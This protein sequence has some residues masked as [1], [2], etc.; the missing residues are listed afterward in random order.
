MKKTAGKSPGLAR[1]ELSHKRIITHANHSHSELTAFREHP[2]KKSKGGLLKALIFVAVLVVIGGVVGILS[3]R[4]QRLERRRETVLIA[5][6]LEAAERAAERAAE[7]MQ[8][9]QG[10]QLEADQAM[11]GIHADV[12]SALG[13][14][15][16][17]APA[18]QLSKVTRTDR[19][20]TPASETPATKAVPRAAREETPDGILS[21][22]ELER[23]LRKKTTGSKAAPSTDD[24]TAA[25]PRPARTR[26]GEATPPIRLNGW[27]AAQLHTQ[28]TATISEAHTS[29]REAEAS[30]G[31]ARAAAV[32]TVVKDSRA[33]IE[34]GALSLETAVEDARGAM[35]DLRK[36]HTLV[37]AERVAVEQARSEQAEREAALRREV[38]A[39]RLAEKELG[40]ARRGVAMARE[41]LNQHQFERAVERLEKTRA[42]LS[43]DSA[44]AH[45]DGPLARLQR[46][47]AL[48]S[49]LIDQASQR[50]LSW[51]WVQD[52]SPV[53]VIGADAETVHLKARRVPWSEVTLPQFLKMVD[54]LLNDSNIRLS[55]R[56]N[57][58]LSA[59][60][61]CYERGEKDKATDF[62]RRATSLI[63]A[64]AD[65]ARQLLAEPANP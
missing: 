59:A 30:L 40:E 10:W 47:Q 19:P 20:G 4:Q 25:A 39:R 48:K 56:A 15:L 36:L 64:K 43:T 16:G 7:A 60:A 57:Q 26:T 44:R 38:E 58:A 49:F 3:V 31:A 33:A 50:P 9:L 1:Q 13:T 27:K 46:A 2:P 65:E 22:E 51:G 6:H 5:T 45:L 52:R 61:Y 41:L 14:P 28:L 12:E 34:R 53:D 18:S 8:T 35:Q 17:E 37:N 55:Q 42:D 54:M 62:S 29:A 63:P 11:H 32:S 21:I 23:R 24:P